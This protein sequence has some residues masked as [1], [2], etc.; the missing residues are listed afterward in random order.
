MYAVRS[1]ADE[2]AD[3]AMQ[4]RK[5]IPRAV[6][7]LWGENTGGIQTNGGEDVFWS[8]CSRTHSLTC[9]G[10][11]A[12]VSLAFCLARSLVKCVR[13]PVLVYAP[14]RRALATGPPALCLQ[15]FLMWSVLTK[16]SFGSNLA[17]AARSRARLLAQ[18]YGPSPGV[19]YSCSDCSPYADALPA[20]WPYAPG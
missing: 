15:A 12:S 5:L 4:C 6:L 14:T 18:P 2:R 19:W 16:T 17:F 9:S 13:G 11:F 1:I 20:S 3:P 8:F 10:T 7:A